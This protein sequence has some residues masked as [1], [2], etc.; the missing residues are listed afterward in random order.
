MVFRWAGFVVPNSAWCTEGFVSGLALYLGYG[1]GTL[2]VYLFA[3]FHQFAGAA[4]DVLHL[5]PLLHF[6]QMGQFGPHPYCSGF[7]TI[8]LGF[9]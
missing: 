8:E 1:K 3:C 5:N 6:F 7:G 9:D 2:A 4:F